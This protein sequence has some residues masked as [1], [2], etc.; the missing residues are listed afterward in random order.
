M[1]I[2]DAPVAGYPGTSFGCVAKIFKLITI[3]SALAT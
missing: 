1:Q 2:R 3:V